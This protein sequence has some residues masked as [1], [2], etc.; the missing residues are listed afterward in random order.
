MVTEQRRQEH[1]PQRVLGVVVAHRDLLEDDV[2]FQLD[3]V[4]GAA[5]VE[6]H[7]GDQVDRQLQIAVEHV[8]VVAGVLLGGE[9]VQ[10]PTDGVHRLRD[11]HGR[12]GRGRLEQQMLEEVRGPGHRGTLVARSDADPDPDRRGAHRGQVFGDH[13]QAAR[14]RGAAQSGL[15]FSLNF[16]ALIA[17][18]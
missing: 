18:P 1:V 17:P 2:A 11:I 7:I 4:G 12:A 6:H 9:R 10:L 14:Q 5:T 8:R 13:A 15:V 3:I 16:G